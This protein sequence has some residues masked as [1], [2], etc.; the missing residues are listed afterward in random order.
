MTS[1]ALAAAF[2][3]LA[4]G[5]ANATV[6]F[7]PLGLPAAGDPQTPPFSDAYAVSNSGVVVGSMF[8]PGE[9]FRAFRWTSDTRLVQ[10]NGTTAESGIFARAITPDS[11]TIVG[12][13]TNPIV[14]FRKLGTGAVEDLGI[15]SP[16]L[17]DASSLSDVSDDGRASAGLL[18]PE[19]NWLDGDLNSDKNADLTDA[20]ILAAYI[21]SGNCGL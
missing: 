20:Q 9:G 14:A 17:Y 10:I 15:P 13:N 12:E 7:P 19:A 5:L 1:K 21:V 18:A 2:I 4:A 6:T 16:D 8:V 11:A 3:A